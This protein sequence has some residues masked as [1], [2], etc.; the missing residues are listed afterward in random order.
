MKSNS[1]DE[2]DT[3]FWRRSDPMCCAC[4]FRRCLILCGQDGKGSIFVI[5]MMYFEQ[6]VRLL[7]DGGRKWISKWPI[8]PKGLFLMGCRVYPTLLSTRGSYNGFF[9]HCC[10]RAEVI[11]L[12]CHHECSIG[13][14]SILITERRID[15]L[16]ENK[17]CTYDTTTRFRGCLKGSPYQL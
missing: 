11:Y 15:F 10:R 6:H 16:K 13:W 2:D 9:T 1:V 14:R 5:G 7:L 17:K 4:F 3:S 8:R 12:C